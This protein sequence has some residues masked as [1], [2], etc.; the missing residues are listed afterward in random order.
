MESGAEMHRF[1][2]V[3][4]LLKKR[5]SLAERCRFVYFSGDWCYNEN[6]EL[7]VFFSGDYL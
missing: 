1:F 2:N 7:C 5:K 6:V 3:Q 4:M